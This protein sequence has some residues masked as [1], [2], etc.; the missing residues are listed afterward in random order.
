M[1]RHRVP[2]CRHESDQDQDGAA[3]LED[4]VHGEAG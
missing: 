2:L 3:D 1:R 4:L